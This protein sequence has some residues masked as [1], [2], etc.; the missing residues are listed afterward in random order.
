MIYLRNEKTSLAIDPLGACVT[1]MQDAYG[2]DIIFPKQT[3]AGKNRGGI[4]LC[5]PIFGP[6]E[7]VGLSQHGFARDLE[8]SIIRQ[9]AYDTELLLEKPNDQ[10]Q[11]PE[12]FSGSLMRYSI[13]LEDVGVKFT[14][15][16]ENTGEQSFACTPAFHPYFTMLD[17]TR[18]T[19]A[20]PD[21]AGKYT[22]EELAGTV[23]LSAPHEVA[24]LKV[25]SRT[26]LLSSPDLKK[27]AIWTDSPNKYLCVE[28]TLDGY[29]NQQNLTDMQLQPGSSK[30]FSML[31]EWK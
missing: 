14:I 21:G 29:L 18:T 22:A 9:T 13:S 6:G 8:W 25:G 3:V 17:A 1:N 19:I 23:F 28:P 11:L 12:Q 24:C 27:Y 30:T 16:I 2:F 20:F 4:P 10:V 31:I 15:T 5:A 7:D 26:V